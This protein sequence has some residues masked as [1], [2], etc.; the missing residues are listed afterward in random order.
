MVLWELLNCEIP[1]RDVDSSAIIWGV[2]NSS[3]TLPIPSSVPRGFALLMQQTWN[4]KPRNRPSFKQ[5]LMHL[6]I[7]SAELNVIEPNHFF[8]IQQQWREEIMNCMKRMKRRRSS[9][10]V[11]NEQKAMNDVYYKEEIE[12][13]IHKRKEELMHAQ[14]VREEYV[15]KRECA[16]NLYMELMTCLLKL[17]QRE[18]N[19]LNRERELQSQMIHSKNH[20]QNDPRILSID[21]HRQPHLDNQ[22][23]SVLQP[24]VKKIPSVV[25]REIYDKNKMIPYTLLDHHI[26]PDNYDHSWRQS[27]QSSSREKISVRHSS[28]IKYKNH[29]NKRMTRKIISP[30]HRK[31]LHS[32]Q[33]SIVLAS[34]ARTPKTPPTKDNDEDFSNH[35]SQSP[36]VK[37]RMY[38]NSTIR[39]LNDPKSDKAIQTNESSFDK[40]SLL[41]QINEDDRSGNSN[42]TL[43]KSTSTNSFDLNANSIP[44]SPNTSN[45]I[46]LLPKMSTAS[47]FD[48]GYG[49]GYQSCLSTPSAHSNKVRFPDKSPVTPV[50]LKSPFNENYF[51]IDIETN[52]CHSCSK[53][54]NNLLNRVKH[55]QTNSNTLPSLSS[56]DENSVNEESEKN[57]RKTSQDGSQLI[58]A[59]IDQVNKKIIANSL[60]SDDEKDSRINYRFNQLKIDSKSEIESESDSDESFI[61]SSDQKSDNDEDD[62]NNPEDSQYLLRRKYFKAINQFNESSQRYCNSISLSSSCDE[63]NDNDG[64]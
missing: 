63:I 4:P 27:K 3:L 22:F 42:G 41:N 35:Q 12:H 32:S 58:S 7:A 15:R 17:E 61:S 28:R 34:S 11:S 37:Q 13:L 1:Y 50:S 5:I 45:H 59:S 49:E 2:G 31:I 52:C 24:I 8:I 14:H 10:A 44:N 6:E 48:S 39:L 60:D 29:R 57:S 64:L 53:T 25:Q 21:T 18:K 38:K 16:N 56:I 40:F 20:C 62:Q 47:T 46:R 26:L 43:H 30:R 54:S 9:V 36:E 51:D 23:L 55:R 19:L 33:N